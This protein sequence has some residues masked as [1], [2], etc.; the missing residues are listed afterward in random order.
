M[1][2]SGT[3]LAYQAKGK[4]GYFQSESDLVQELNSEFA[5]ANIVMR[6]YHSAWTSTIGAVDAYLGGP[7]DY[8]F[9]ATL[10]TTADFGSADD[11]R[12]IAD[13]ALYQ[14]TGTLP[15]STIPNMTV[16]KGVPT[17]TGQPEQATPAAASTGDILGLGS[18]LQG[19]VNSFALLMAGV[20]LAVVLIIAGKHKAI[21]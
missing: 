11:I 10:Q 16:P 9:T 19:G 17:D 13:H 7:A 1:I 2:P 5:Q 21:I 20:I 15:A 6:D 12:S 14:V 18:L 4:S 8:Q 3:V